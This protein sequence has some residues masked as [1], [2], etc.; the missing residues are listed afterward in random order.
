MKNM[1]DKKAKKPHVPVSS[2]DQAE[3]INDISDS[4]PNEIVDPD[5]GKVWK[6][7]EDYS[8]E[9]EAQALCQHPTLKKLGFSF[10]ICP[11]CKVIFQIPFSLQYARLQLMEHLQGML[12]K[13]DTY[14]VKDENK[15]ELPNQGQ[16]Q[17]A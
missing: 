13:L 6:K 3:K 2:N 14:F 4:L 9:A 16:T 5:T 7:G 8:V 11:E 15:D 10:Y 17:E 1:T 12:S